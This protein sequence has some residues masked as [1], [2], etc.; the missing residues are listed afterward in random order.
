MPAAPI[1]HRVAQVPLIRLPR[2]AAFDLR[3]VMDS[4]IDLDEHSAAFRIRARYGADRP[5][6]LADE[7]AITHVGQTLTLAL[8]VDA[9]DATDGSTLTLA[10]LQAEALN[11]W[12]LDFRD[13]NDALALRLQGDL[14]W[15]PEEGAWDDEPRSVATI[16]E[17]TVTIAAGGAVTVTVAVI[18]G[19]ASV[20]NA[21]VNAAIEQNAAASRTALGLGS[22]ATQATSAFEAAGSVAALASSVTT[23]LAGKAATTHGHAIADVT[24]LQT[25]LD[26]KQASDPD[27][28][29]IA[30]LTSAADKAPYFTGSGTA[31]L[32]DLTSF[33]RTLLDDIDAATARGTLGLGSSS[34]P[35]FAGLTLSAG[36]LT[37]NAPFT[38]SQTWNNA[39]VAF[40][41]LVVDCTNTASA[42]GSYP[43]DIRVGGAPAFRVR[44][45]SVNVVW[46]FN[47]YDVLHAGFFKAF[48]ARAVSNLFGFPTTMSLVWGTD[49]GNTNYDLALR[50]GAAATLQ[51]GEDHATTP[52]AQTIRAHGVTT[53]TGASLTLQ[54][55]SGSV[56]RG[57]VVLHGGNRAAYD[58]APSTTVIRDILI[59]H[60]LMAAS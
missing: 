35:T 33:A 45:D 18:T 43:L 3:V 4:E 39:A 21:A 46:D 24:A 27:L 1:V 15:L 41:G 12:R 11:A 40:S 56:A 30:G 8:A 51:L 29:A 32:F 14:E 58:A 44:R 23:E 57:N 25:V 6:F 26:G 31:A 5:I 16:P 38:F 42:A 9:A 52:T 17:I 36:T 22:A 48:S 10:D 19:G 13:D 60:G 7:A 59:S 2:G 50:R 34:S 20:D 53:G 55:G 49:V 54:G 28:T 47:G 37:A